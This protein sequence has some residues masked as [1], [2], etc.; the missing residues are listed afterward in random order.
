MVDVAEFS[1]T[2][3]SSLGGAGVVVIGLSSLIGRIWAARVL[4]QEQIK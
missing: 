4:A 3:L 1:F 2:A